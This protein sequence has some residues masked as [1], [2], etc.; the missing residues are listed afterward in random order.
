MNVETQ[1][2]FARRLGVNKSTVSRWKEAGRLEM[3]GDRVK[4]ERSLI[5]LDQTKGDRSDLAQLHEMAREAK[6]LLLQE[7]EPQALRDE[8]RI[9]ALDKARDE[10]RIKRAD[11]DMKEMERDRQAGSL[12][13]IEDVD[14][15]LQDFGALLRV[16]LDGRAERYGAEQGLA[17][18][19]ITG[20]AE[21]DEAIL[22]EL[23]EKLKTRA[24]A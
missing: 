23:S 8:L 21:S 4:V 1:S 14:Y 20:L 24:A 7:S 17:P 9:A 2:A 13:A 18:D 19:Q 16:M 10:A 22:L 5:L 11:A 15:V 3:D 12:I 6:Q